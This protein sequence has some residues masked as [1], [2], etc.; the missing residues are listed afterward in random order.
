MFQRLRDAI[1]STLMVSEARF[2]QHFQASLEGYN[3][4]NCYQVSPPSTQPN[5]TQPNPT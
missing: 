1:V 4:E 2:H 5:P 3:C